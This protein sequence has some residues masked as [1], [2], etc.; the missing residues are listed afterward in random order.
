MSSGAAI[1]RVKQ[2]HFHYIAEDDVAALL[3]CTSPLFFSSGASS[4]DPSLRSKVMIYDV[5]L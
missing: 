3:Y 1:F 2:R 4:E 5:Y